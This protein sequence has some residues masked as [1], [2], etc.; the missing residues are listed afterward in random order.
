MVSE[1]DAQHEGNCPYALNDVLLQLYVS[2]ASR[3]R[4]GTRRIHAERLSSTLNAY[5]SFSIHFDARIY[6][7]RVLNQNEPRQ[8]KREPIDQYHK[9]AKLRRD[10]AMLM[11]PSLPASQTRPPKKNPIS[12]TSTAEGSGIVVTLSE[13]WLWSAC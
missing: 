6:S 5:I 11:E 12:H 9:A 3:K 1:L 4:G 10:H 13:Y 2:K 7:H 8:Q